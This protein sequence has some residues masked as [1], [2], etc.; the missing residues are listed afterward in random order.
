MKA[1]AIIGT[2]TATTTKI[3][4]FVGD[5]HM[6]LTVVG[7]PLSVADAHVRAIPDW[8]LVGIVDPWERFDYKAESCHRR[9]A[10]IRLMVQEGYFPSL[11]PPLD[12][13]EDPDT[14][15]GWYGY[16]W[17]KMAEGMG[18]PFPLP[19]GCQ[20]LQDFKGLYVVGK[21]RDL[22][23]LVESWARE[24]CVDIWRRKAWETWTDD[25]L[26]SAE[27]ALRLSLPNF[28]IV[29]A[30]VYKILGQVGASKAHC[31][32]ESVLE[33]NTRNNWPR[34]TRSELITAW[35]MSLAK[36]GS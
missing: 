29:Q 5:V 22:R 1:L 18:Y 11:S 13:P 15:L 6:R 36:A 7:G 14:R 35:D 24:T 28:L 33:A 19:E 25:Q 20:Q 16:E 32:L 3:L 2:P 27:W 30:T 17:L 10:R 23:A 8:A 12:L 21:E 26:E 4:G 34:S 31:Y 9:D